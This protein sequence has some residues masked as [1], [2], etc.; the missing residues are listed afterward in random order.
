MRRDIANEIVVA[1]VA[2]AVIAFALTFGILLTLSSSTGV[3]QSGGGTNVAGN[4]VN[5]M[6]TNRA[7]LT[8]TDDVNIFTLLAP[9]GSVTPT[10]QDVEVSTQTP[11][12]T[13]AATSTR[14]SAPTETASATDAI[15]TAPTATFTRTAVSSDT[16]TLA[17][18]QT[19]SATSSPTQTA[20]PSATPSS[21]HT[22]TTAATRTPSATST[23]TPTA[24]P[25]ATRTFTRTPLPTAT[26]TP[27]VEVVGCTDPA[28]ASITNPRPGDRLK[29]V[30]AVS[31]TADSQDFRF[32]KLEVR[33]DSA[34]TYSFWSRAEKSVKQGELGRID[35][36]IFGKGAYWV[37]VVVE[38]SA[39]EVSNGRCEVPVF[40]E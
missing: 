6:P 40:F 13:E 12:H 10:E 2:V 25:T 30:F 14:T 26:I 11:T 15:T 5:T 9:T 34:A 38:T 19:P 18:T 24:T 37:R 27:V 1:I 16:A 21:T 4:G 29:G 33:P 20:M 7:T 28:I 36:N 23:P 3:F 22:S 8:P 17:P 35:A 31:G 39:G 32:Y